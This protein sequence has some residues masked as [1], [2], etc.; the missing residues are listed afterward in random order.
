MQGP[1]QRLTSRPF[2]SPRGEGHYGEEDRNNLRPVSYRGSRR[3]GFSPAPHATEV[4]GVAGTRRDH[5][6]RRRPVR[7]R[8]V[9]GQFKQKTKEPISG[10]LLTCL[11]SMSPWLPGARYV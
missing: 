10:S 6:I 3:E 2:P 11:F 1:G 8:T 4:L 5:T 9:H 7:T